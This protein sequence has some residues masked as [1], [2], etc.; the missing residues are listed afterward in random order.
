MM[1][2]PCCTARCLLVAWV[3]AP[4]VLLCRCRWLLKNPLRSGV[5]LSTPYRKNAPYPSTSMHSLSSRPQSV[6]G[7]QLR[8]RVSTP[9]CFPRLHV[10]RRGEPR[11]EKGTGECHALHSSDLSG[12]GCRGAYHTFLVWCEACH[13]AH[14]SFSSTLHSLLSFQE[15]NRNYWS[16]SKHL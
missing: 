15:W 13:D 12:R 3:P 6:D 11:D 7:S 8:G 2:C 16:S 10:A 5:L 9:R 4:P 1:E 14:S